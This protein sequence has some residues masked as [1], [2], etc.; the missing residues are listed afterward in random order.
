MLRLNLSS[1]LSLFLPLICLLTSLTVGWISYINIKAVL[2]AQTFDYLTAMQTAKTAEI[3]RYVERIANQIHT[4]E[5]TLIQQL[6]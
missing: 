3:E 6:R 4:V 1:K 5:K 2:E